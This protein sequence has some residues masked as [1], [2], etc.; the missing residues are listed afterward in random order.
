MY[1]TTLCTCI[2]LCLYLAKKAKARK[3]TPIAI[4]PMALPIIL[5]AG[6][7]FPTNGSAQKSIRIAYFGET[8]THYGLRGGTEYNLHRAERNKPD[9][10]AAYNVVYFGVTLTAYRHPHNHVGLI[11]APELGWRHTGRRG[12][13][14]QAAL[15]PGFFRSFYEGKTWKASEN[16]Q[17]ERVRLAGQWGF[18]PG[19]SA[20]F[21][22]RLGRS[23]SV[24][25]S[26]PESLSWYCNLHYLRQYPYNHSFLNR[27]ALELGILK[28]LIPKT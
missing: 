15:S 21:G 8:V 19:I 18:L 20:G 4:K 2:Y 24:V 26:V 7:S 23:Q 12:G 13:I 11:L 17:F 1:Y 3:W 25:M 16:A 5:L 14:V 28:N 6:L 9:G 10:R 22:H 27:F